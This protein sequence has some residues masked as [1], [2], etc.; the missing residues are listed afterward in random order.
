MAWPLSAHFL[1][2]G[3]TLKCDR[4]KKCA[5]YENVLYKQESSVLKIY[6]LL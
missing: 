2:S 6:E 3:L 1:D 4:H 5:K